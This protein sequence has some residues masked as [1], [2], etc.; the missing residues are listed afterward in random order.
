M[1]C[2]C[3]IHTQHLINW[4]YSQFH[5][6]GSTTGKEVCNYLISQRS[7]LFCNPINQHQHKFGILCHSEKQNGLFQELIQLDLISPASKIFTRVATLEDIRFAIAYTLSVRLAASWNPVGKWFI[8][9][10][11]QNFLDVEDTS[12][13]FQAIQ[14]EI[15]LSGDHN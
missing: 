12:E 11:Q 5:L 4:K 6:S 2:I 13:T 10:E 7:Q 14:F 15:R 1:K 9:R 3:T 8:H